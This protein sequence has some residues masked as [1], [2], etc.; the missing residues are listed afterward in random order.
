M[1]IKYTK[2]FVW[3]KDGFGLYARIKTDMSANVHVY[4]VIK[5][6]ESNNYCDV[7]IL[8]NSKPYTHSDI[9]QV[10]N[11]IHCGIDETKVV[12]VAIKD[13]ETIYAD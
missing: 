13:M 4:K 7:P 3:T 1:Q 2:P 10:A 6:F 9:T 8:I 11:V 12:R 5:I